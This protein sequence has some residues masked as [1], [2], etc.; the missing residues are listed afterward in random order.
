M[1]ASHF[2]FVAE[3]GNDSLL[4]S[5]ELREMTDLLK[6]RQGLVNLIIKDS[7]SEDGK[8]YI[9]L[10]TSEWVAELVQWLLRIPFSSKRG[11]LCLF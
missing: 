4:S 6:K 1:K 7:N 3:N 5:D 10:E 11:V 9:N 2:E 8:K